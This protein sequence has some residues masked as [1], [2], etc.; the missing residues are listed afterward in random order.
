MSRNH[1]THN[2]DSAT[3]NSAGSHRESRVLHTIR[4]LLAK[5]ESTSYPEE[6][7]ALTAKA[8]ELIAAHAIDLALIEE[9]TGRGQVSSRILFIPAPYPKEKYM[10]LGG[11]AQA[12]NCRAIYGLEDAQFREMVASGELFS[13][14]GNH[15]TLVGYE[16]DLDAVELVFTSLLVQAV[17]IMLSH[18][19]QVDGAGRNRTKSFRRSFLSGF[20]W[21]VSSRL[22]EATSAA[23][24]AADDAA[25]GSV[26]P[27][28][29][30]RKASVDEAV[31]DRFSKL[32]KLKTS[33]TNYDGIAAGNHAGNQADLGQTKV[34][35][36]RA[37]L[38]P[39][40]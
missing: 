20:A 29:A 26:L 11:V 4:A 33:V 25:S 21:T 39:S 34:G 18:G 24:A 32:G 36:T 30:S 15:A 1:T 3:T 8:Q 23:G 12:N 28:L 40:P 38:S 5:A 27:V 9:Q 35:T 31:Q 2:T 13:R 22:S 16:S 7:A 37:R 6:A 17:N 10:L 19:P 14:N